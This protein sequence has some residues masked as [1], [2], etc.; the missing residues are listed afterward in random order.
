MARLCLTMGSRTQVLHISEPPPVV[1]GSLG[2]TGREEGTG[3]EAIPWRVALSP[4]CVQESLGSLVWN[5]DSQP[6]LI[7]FSR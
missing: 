3:E 2:G 1:N 4:P 7:L 6:H 5:V